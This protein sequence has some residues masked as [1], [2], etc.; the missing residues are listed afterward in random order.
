MHTGKYSI[1][2]IK[3]IAIIFFQ[4]R[5]KRNALLELCLFPIIIF[6]QKKLSI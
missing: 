1:F 3:P 4:H 5:P 6:M 2:Y